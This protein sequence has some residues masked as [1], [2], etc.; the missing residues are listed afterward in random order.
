MESKKDNP[1]DTAMPCH[2]PCAKGG[3]HEPKPPR[4]GVYTNQSLPCA[5]VAAQLLG[6]WL[7][8]GETEGL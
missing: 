8:V 7:A 6:R 4:K 2:P 5:G 1:P 3:L